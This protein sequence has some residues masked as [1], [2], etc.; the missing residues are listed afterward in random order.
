MA[1]IVNYE[2][3]IQALKE[4]IEKKEQELDNL[5]QNLEEL[6]NKHN[7]QKNHE[8]VALMKERGLSASEAVEIVKR[9]LDSQN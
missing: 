6:K 9:A 7:Q 4:K 3:K 1:R 2:E 8:L 5:R